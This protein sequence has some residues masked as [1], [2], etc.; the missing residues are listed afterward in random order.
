MPYIKKVLETVHKVDI[1]WDTYTE[2]SLKA[3]TREQ[4]GKGRPRRIT[5]GGELPGSW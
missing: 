2:H 1:V 5:G 4:R 3:V